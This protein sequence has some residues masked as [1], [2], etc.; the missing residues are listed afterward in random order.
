ME[1]KIKLQKFSVPDFVLQE[2][3]IGKRQEGFNE[4][5]SYALSDLDVATLSELCEQFRKDIFEKANKIDPHAPN[6][7]TV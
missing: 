1:I 2:G 3:R 6:R 5:P 7:R 4:P